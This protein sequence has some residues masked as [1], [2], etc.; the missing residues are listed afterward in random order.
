MARDDGVYTPRSPW[1]YEASD[2]TGRAIR[3]SIPFDEGTRSI[4]GPASVFRDADCLYTRI[5]IG[6]GTDGKVESSTKVF[7]V[8]AG[9][10]SITRQQLAG[11]GFSSY[12]D[13]NS[14]QVT[15]GA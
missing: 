10:T 3:I 12:D 2:V 4:N 13:L 11:R 14:A 8:P 5:Y 15:A 7:L 9:S 1:T 6:F